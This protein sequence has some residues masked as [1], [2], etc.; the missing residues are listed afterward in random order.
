MINPI[1]LVLIANKD[2]WLKKIWSPSNCH[3]FSNSIARKGCMPH[4]FENLSTRTFP[5]HMTTPL[6]GK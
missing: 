2:E 5:K 1:L 4:V 3:D 6:S